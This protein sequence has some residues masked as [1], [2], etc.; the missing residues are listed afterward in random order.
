MARTGRNVGAGGTHD[1]NEHSLR[2]KSYRPTAPALPTDCPD[3]AK[4]VIPAV[5]HLRLWACAILWYG[6][7]IADGRCA[8][9][10]GESNYISK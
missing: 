10:G 5:E 2:L 8:I 6:E 3:L 9:V 4:F 7:R 1:A